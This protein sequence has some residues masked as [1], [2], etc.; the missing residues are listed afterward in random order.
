MSS[1]IAYTVVNDVKISKRE[2]PDNLVNASELFAASMLQPEKQTEIRNAILGD[3]WKQ[4]STG[5]WCTWLHC[6][7][8]VD[9]TLT[10]ISL[11][12]ARSVSRACGPS[13][14][15]PDLAKF[16]SDN[17]QTLAT[18][19]S[20][21]RLPL[22][23]HDS[24]TPCPAPK[25]SKNRIVRTTSLSCPLKLVTDELENIWE[26]NRR[27]P[28]AASRRQWALARNIEPSRVHHWFSNRVR[29]A[30]QEGIPVTPGEYHL[31][32]GNPKML[33]GFSAPKITR[34]TRATR[35]TPVVVD[36][37][38]AKE[39]T[40]SPPPE[41]E[42]PLILMPS[43]RYQTVSEHENWYDASYPEQNSCKQVHLHPNHENSYSTNM[44]Y[45]LDVLSTV[46]TPLYFDFLPAHGF[47]EHNILSLRPKF[48]PSS[49]PTSIPM[50][51]S[52]ISWNSCTLEPISS[53]HA[54]PLKTFWFDGE[55]YTMDGLYAG[56]SFS[57]LMADF[58][59]HSL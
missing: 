12:V 53:I 26:N 30:R 49:D 14:S 40:P 11:E 46:A 35:M 19:D 59:S 3:D 50:E 37:P 29:K 5:T 55:E 28:T 45:N 10:R 16:L 38:A 21:N 24:N 33:R 47:D 31:D 2:A 54:S 1:S 48:K 56:K 52:A 17:P 20:S 13:M 51:L 39:P 9:L 34:T 15:S 44:Q 58:G 4:D 41:P 43:P 18:K 42:D 36:V 23:P 22:R 25:L 7:Y 8:I 57:F 27:I 32:V 6:T